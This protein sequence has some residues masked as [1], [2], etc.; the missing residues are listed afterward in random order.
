MTLKTYRITGN[1]VRHALRQGKLLS[2]TCPN[3]LHSVNV[4]P[5]IATFLGEEMGFFFSIFTS[6][7]DGS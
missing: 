6:R 1:K 3:D 5:S 4:E 2:S 7:K